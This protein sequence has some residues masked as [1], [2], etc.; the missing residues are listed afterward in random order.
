MESERKQRFSASTPVKVAAGVV[1]GTIVVA[2]LSKAVRLRHRRYAPEVVAQIQ[3]LVRFAQSGAAMAGQDTQPLIGLQHVTEALANARMARALVE[4]SD[5]VRV[6][7]VNINDLI[8][9]LES[10]QHM[11]MQQIGM[12][13]PQLS[14]AP[15]GGLIA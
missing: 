11:L 3:R 9:A 1:V 12:L 14:L 13:C 4:P 5:I 2:M 15:V 10:Q 7:G 6:T 8:D